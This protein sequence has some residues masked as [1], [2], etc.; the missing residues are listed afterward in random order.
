[1]SSF[2]CAPDLSDS[3]SEDLES[4]GEIEGSEMSDKDRNDEGERKG[5][6]TEQDK[7]DED[8]ARYWELMQKSG[9][10]VSIS[11]IMS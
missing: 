4:S 1:M 6:D 11:P 8:E 3:S 2:S 7:E 5:G 9:H 10:K